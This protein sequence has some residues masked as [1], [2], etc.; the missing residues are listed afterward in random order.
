[1]IEMKGVKFETVFSE[2]KRREKWRE[3]LVKKYG[4]LGNVL[5][6]A[7]KEDFEEFVKELKEEIKEGIIDKMF[8]DLSEKEKVKMKKEIAIQVEKDYPLAF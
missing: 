2:E 8:S 4:S 6:S 1:V 3:F 7:K 5:I